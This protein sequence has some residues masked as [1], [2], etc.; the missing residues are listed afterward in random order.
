MVGLLL[1][2]ARPTTRVAKPAVSD[3]SPRDERGTCLPWAAIPRGMRPLLIVAPSRS[4]A[5][6]CLLAKIEFPFPSPSRRLDA[7]LAPSEIPA[8]PPPPAGYYP[9]Q[10]REGARRSTCLSPEAKIAIVM[11]GWLLRG[12]PRSGNSG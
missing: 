1:C 4:P 7:P 10:Q 2:S 12:R 11:M 8:L 3:S 5:L 9:R 6:A